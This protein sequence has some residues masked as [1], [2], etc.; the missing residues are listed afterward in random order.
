[1]RKLLLSL[2]LSIVSLTLLAQP[3][4]GY[5]SNASG[6]AGEQLMEALHDI[7]KDHTSLSYTQLWDAFYDTDMREDGYVLDIYSGCDFE[8]DVDRDRGAGGNIE[9]DFYNREHSFPSSWFGSVKT[10][11]MYT[12][13][14]HIYPAD[15]KVNAVRANY[16]YGEVGT[17]SYTS[18]N[19]SKLGA[20]SFSGYNGIVFE[21]IDE[22]KGD[23]ARTYFYMVTRYYDVA[24]NWNTPMLNGTAYPAFT[25]WSLTL[26]L[27][28][29]REDP[30]SQKEID[31]NN[32]IYDSYQENRNPFIDNPDFA[33]D[34]WGGSSHTTMTSAP[35]SRITISP[36]PAK[37]TIT[38]VSTIKGR[39]EVAIYNIVGGRTFSIEAQSIAE[40]NPI[41]ISHLPNGVYLVNVTHGEGV[42]TIRLVISK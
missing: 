32:V 5:Y 28:W 1:M 9:C 2:F 22:Y 21:P 10:S 13:L 17:T 29:H 20:S 36:N 40:I 37:E 39:V 16:P 8:F 42:S 35:K 4:E 19:G 31:R 12:D 7:I 18:S 25:Q 27:K 14:F 3:P 33:Y 23:L 34:I 15:K 24:K 38:L 41:D 26:L 6:K 30:V 11:P